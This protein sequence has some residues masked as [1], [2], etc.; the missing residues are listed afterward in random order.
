M[1]SV[2]EFAYVCVCVCFS[3]HMY[4]TR[5]CMHVCVCACE[6]FT[7]VQIFGLATENEWV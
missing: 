1:L 3:V 2:C 5:A 7:S 6:A 4:V